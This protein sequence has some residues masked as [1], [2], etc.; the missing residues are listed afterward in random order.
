MTPSVQATTTLSEWKI[1][2]DIVVLII[3]AGNSFYTWWSGREKVTSKRFAALEK[4][5][6]QRSTV[7]AAVEQARQIQELESKFRNVPSCCNSHN[8]TTGRLDGHNTRLGQHKEMLNAIEGELKHLPTNKD[9]GVLHEKINTVNAHLSDLK[10]E[11]NKVV[12]AMPGVTHLTEMMN[13]FLLNQGRK[14]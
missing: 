9:L 8:D 5:V 6:A 1:Y 12:G 13:E 3:V 11:V 14:P 4:E 10:A 7:D 2:I